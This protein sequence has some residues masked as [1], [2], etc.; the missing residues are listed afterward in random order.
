[1]HQASEGAFTGEISAPMLV[2]LGVSGVV[3]GHSE[4]R[5]YFGETDRAVAKKVLAALEAGLAPIL[6]V[7]E[8]EEE[9]LAGDTERKLRHQVQEGLEHVPKARARRRR[10]RLRAD[11]GDR[12]RPGRDGRAGAGGGEFRAR[13]R[14]SEAKAAGKLVRVLYGGSVSADQRRR[15][16]GPAR[17]R[18]GPGRR[19]LARGGVLRGDRRRR[20]A[21]AR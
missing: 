4:R 13:P 21:A 1:M 18:R 5:Q 17:R 6:C 14:R 10:D 11:L 9:R 12:D 15:A 7:G 19:R 20:P 3:L 2:E 16:A 8:S